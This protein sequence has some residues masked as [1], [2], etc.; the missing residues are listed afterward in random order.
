[1]QNLSVEVFDGGYCLHSERSVIKGGRIKSVKFPSMFF[2]IRHPS[3]GNILFDTGYS[4][5][6]HEETKKFPEKIYSWV[7]PVRVKESDLAITK[8]RQTG[9]GIPK[10]VE[11]DVT[12][13]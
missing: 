4:D 1:M 12:H 9:G 5:Q 13:F 3:R 8:L 2:L 11:I 7:T 6:F 10:L